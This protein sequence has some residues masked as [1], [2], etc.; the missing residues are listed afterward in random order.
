VIHGDAIA[1]S[2]GVDLEG[3]P[4]SLAHSAFDRLGNSAE[5]DMPRDNLAKAIHNTNERLLQL[6]LSASHSSQQSSMRGTLNA[7]L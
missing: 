3:G 6:F 2:D 7:M 4:S 5:V 1:D